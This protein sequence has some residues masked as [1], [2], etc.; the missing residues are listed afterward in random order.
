[1]LY[2]AENHFDDQGGL[3]FGVNFESMKTRNFSSGCETIERLRIAFT[4]NVRF[5][6]H[7]FS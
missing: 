1:M 3:T 5:A 6:F 4:A 7:M 2:T